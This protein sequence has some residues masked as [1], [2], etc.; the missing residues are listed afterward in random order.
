[1]K[2]QVDDTESEQTKGDGDGVPEV[3]ETIA[4]N[5]EIKNIGAGEAIQPYVRLKNR[6][7]KQ[8]DL[9]KGTLEMGSHQKDG[10]FIHGRGR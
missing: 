7:K 4:L 8:I 2:I 6:S 5:I 9:I 10:E 3:G 1:M